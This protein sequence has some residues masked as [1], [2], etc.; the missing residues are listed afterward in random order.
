MSEEQVKAVQAEMKRL[1]GHS[2]TTKADVRRVFEGYM[3]G[4]YSEC[5]KSRLY[6][7]HGA[8]YCE[9]LSVVRPYAMQAKE[10]TA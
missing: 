9:L 3:T 7:L 4:D 1:R 10:Q 2:Y 6:N 8:E 5:H